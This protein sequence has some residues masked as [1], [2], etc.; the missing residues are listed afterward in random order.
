MHKSK[1]ICIGL[2]Y[3]YFWIYYS[4]RQLFL[5]SVI[6]NKQLEPSTESYELVNLSENGK[7]RL[8]FTKSCIK[9]ICS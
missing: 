9:N 3:V 2:S 6:N 1:Y 5:A 7:P 4:I 8:K